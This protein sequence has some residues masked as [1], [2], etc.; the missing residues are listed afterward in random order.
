MFCTAKE[1]K[2]EKAGDIMAEHDCKLCIWERTHVK[3]YKVFRKAN[4]KIHKLM[5]YPRR[6]RQ[7]N[8]YDFN[9]MRGIK[10][11]TVL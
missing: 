5:H 7:R 11:P 1:I 8:M 2:S 10:M 4:S 9:K 6:P 3:A